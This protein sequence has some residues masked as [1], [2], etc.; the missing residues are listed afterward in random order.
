MLCAYNNGGY[1][2]NNVPA[3][4]E[5]NFYAIGKKDG[6]F[7]YGNKTIKISRNGIANIEVKKVQYEEMKKM[8]ASL[9]YN[10]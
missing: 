10:N 7:Y 6:E 8:F 4:E 3:N 9:G 1:I 5:V 2:V